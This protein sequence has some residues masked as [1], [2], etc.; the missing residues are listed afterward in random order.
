MGVDKNKSSCFLN[1]KRRLKLT[2]ELIH[3][4]FVMVSS[5][6]TLCGNSASVP[7]FIRILPCF[8]SSVSL[9]GDETKADQWSSFCEQLISEMKRSGP[10]IQPQ[11]IT[12]QRLML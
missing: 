11:H 1:A 3:L 9:K 6:V 4:I 10:K 2:F 7:T 5:L 12:P 8:V